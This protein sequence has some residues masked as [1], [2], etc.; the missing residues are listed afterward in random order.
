MKRSR[1]AEDDDDAD[2]AV[3]DDRSSVSPRHH[4]D[5]P[6][7][8]LAGLDP[9]HA[10]QDPAGG[11]DMKCSLP[12]HA[13]SLSFTSYD[14]YQTHYQ[15]S[16]TNRCLE[17]RGNFP[18]A[19]LL[20]VHIEECHDSFVAV[21]REKGEHTVRSPIIPRPTSADLFTVLLFRRGVREEVP[22]A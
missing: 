5:L 14:E 21:K 12:G 17:C 2:C 13:E 3:E 22:D 10:A 4:D 8:K 20:G 7:A 16:H 18:S 1:E 6:A 15:K 9:A 11:I 19:H